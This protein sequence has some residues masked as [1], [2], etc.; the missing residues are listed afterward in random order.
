MS[1]AAE[2]ERSADAR[3]TLAQ[4]KEVLARSDARRMSGSVAGSLRGHGSTA[5]LS[6]SMAES[7]TDEAAETPGAQDAQ[8]MA[9]FKAFESEESKKF[10]GA[11]SGKEER[12]RG[13]WGPQLQTDTPEEQGTE[14]KHYLLS[15]DADY[16]EAVRNADRSNF[17]SDPMDCSVK[18]CDLMQGILAKTYT[19]I[20]S[21]FLGMDFEYGM[22]RLS[23]YTS[24]TKSLRTLL[25]LAENTSEQVD[26]VAERTRELQALNRKYEATIRTL[27]RQLEDYHTKHQAVGRGVDGAF[28]AHGGARDYTKGPGGAVAGGLIDPPAPGESSTVKARVGEQFFIVLQCEDLSY[29]RKKVDFVRH[30]V[31]ALQTEIIAPAPVFNCTRTNYFVEDDNPHGKTVTA[32]I[33]CNWM[34][35]CTAAHDAVAF[36]L[37]VH[38]ALQDSQRWNATLL[39][40]PR[41]NQEIWRGLRVRI[42]VHLGQPSEMDLGTDHSV[43]HYEGAPVEKTL[44]VTSLAIAGDVVM[45]QSAY[46][47][48]LLTKGLVTSRRR[49]ST[50]SLGTAQSQS[51]RRHLGTAFGKTSF[52]SGSGAILC[53]NVPV[54]ASTRS[55]AL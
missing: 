41:Y 36:A 3:A 2:E 34:F 17:L 54:T 12:D 7:D 13:I 33:N 38:Q 24:F 49:L 44:R 1:E 28:K 50:P 43:R 32:L 6:R 9:E 48:R 11:K 46:D 30:M 35:V 25:Y 10:D 26:T 45:S 21:L 19:T 20:R 5:K 14:L 40:Q 4:M 37:T 39:A 51:F 8:W 27:R 42:G 29:F 16:A 47:R 15:S 31:E 52:F 55:L 53:R 22:S 18:N 23:S